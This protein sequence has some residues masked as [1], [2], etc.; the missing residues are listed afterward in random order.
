[1]ARQF[2]FSK[3]KP[4]IQWIVHQT[5][6]FWF[7]RKL[8]LCHVCSCAIIG[9]CINIYI[10]HIGLFSVLPKFEVTC[11]TPVLPVTQLSHHKWRGLCKVSHRNCFLSFERKHFRLFDDDRR[12]FQIGINRIIVWYMCLISISISSKGLKKPKVLS[13][14]KAISQIHW[15]QDSFFL[16]IG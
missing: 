7:Y 12:L 2:F 4:V 5:S 10:I 1:M 3:S 15:C 9:T 14:S 8:S 6:K 13:L 11:N 16:P